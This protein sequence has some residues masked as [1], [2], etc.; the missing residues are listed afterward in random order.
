MSLLLE[1]AQ[2]QVGLITAAQLAEIGIARSTTSYRS[3]IGRM[4]TRVLPGVHLTHGGEPDR[5]QREVAAMLY[6]GDRV[7]ITG[8]AALRHH[9]LNLTSPTYAVSDADIVQVLIPHGNRRLS[10]AFVRVERTRDIPVATRTATYPS[11][12]IAPAARAVG[13]ACRHLRNAGDAQ[14]LV[15]EAIRFGYAS[16]ADLEAVLRFAPRQGSAFLRSSIEHARAGIWSAPESE[17][18]TLIATTDL[19][20]PIWNRQLR[21]SSGRLIAIPDAWFDEVGLAVEVDSRRHHAGADDWDRTLARQASYARAGV[22]SLQLSPRQI[23]QEPELV[24]VSIVEAHQA[25]AR[26]PRPDVHVSEP[27][28]FDPMTSPGMPWAG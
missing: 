2:A 7:V 21:S 19:P 15:S 18:R 16:I 6:C 13:D 20:E 14:T 10:T 3:G 17:L 25:A 4:W 28:I 5:L 22:M 1:V 23:R 8:I 11:I 12:P 27:V 26:L 24:I 9:G